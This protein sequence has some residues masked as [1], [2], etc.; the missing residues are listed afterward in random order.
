MVWWY[1]QDYT[2]IFNLHSILL[3]R[4]KHRSASIRG[5]THVHFVNVSSIHELMQWVWALP[6][7]EV[8]WY[9]LFKCAN[10][11]ETQYNIVWFLPG[12]VFLLQTIWGS[13]TIICNMHFQLTHVLGVV[14]ARDA[15]ARDPRVWGHRPA[16]FPD[17][18]LD[19]GKEH[20]SKQI[21]SS[22][23]VQH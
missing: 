22:N 4:L 15:N 13:Q 6:S 10:A 23:K 8:L 1:E 20:I 5:K 19:G 7:T 9:Y 21:S 12:T 17:W 18:E 2:C 3:L 16:A 11:I 14:R